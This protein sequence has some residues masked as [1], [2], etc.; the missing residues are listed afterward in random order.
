MA[1]DRD[2]DR[3]LHE[4]GWAVLRIWE[5]EP[6]E[7]AADR[8]AAELAR[9]RPRDACGCVLDPDPHLAASTDLGRADASPEDG[10]PD[11]S[12]SE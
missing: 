7:A 5:H 1:H 10:E 8:V 3:R 4:A 2:T 6:T 12:L 11:G 9:R